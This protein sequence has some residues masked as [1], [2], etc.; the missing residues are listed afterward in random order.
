MPRNGT[1]EERIA[2]TLLLNETLKHEAFARRFRFV[3]QY[4]P[5]ANKRGLLNLKMS[6]DAAHVTPESIKRDIELLC[7]FSPERV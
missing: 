3:D 5:F 7:S 1:D 2:W 4:S 6:R